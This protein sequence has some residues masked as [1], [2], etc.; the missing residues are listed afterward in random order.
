MVIIVILNI[1]FNSING[2]IYINSLPTSFKVYNETSNITI[3]RPIL[4]RRDIN[5]NYQFNI[6]A[7]NLLKCISPSTGI[8]CNN[9]FT[10]K[11][12]RF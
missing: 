12:N 6:Y 7:G 8:W 3:N 1:E 2:T 10:I 5:I 4:I 11:T 9:K